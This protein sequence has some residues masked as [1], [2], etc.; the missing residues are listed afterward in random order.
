MPDPFIVNGKKRGRPG[1]WIVDYYLAPH[2]RT[3]RTFKTK[4]AAKAFRL[5]VLKEEMQ[6]RESEADL[7]AMTL[8]E[9]AKRR[10]LRQIK[11]TVKPRTYESYAETVRLHLQPT[12]GNIR[13]RHLTRGRIK[14][15]LVGK[16]SV[17]L[18]RN[19]VRIIQAVLSAMLNSAVDDEVILAN[20][21]SKLG[22]SLR[23]AAAPSLRQEQIKAMT[24][25]Q[26]GA[27]LKATA[28][29]APAYVPLFLTLARA[30][31]RLGEALGLHWDDLNFAQREIRVERTID[32]QGRAGTPKV[33]NG[34]TIQMSPQ[35]ATTLLRL[36]MGR[37]ERMKRHKWTTLPPWVFCTRSGR[38]LEPHNVR[39]VFRTCL[40]A[41][42]L[43]RHFTPHC[44][45]HTYASILLQEGEAP[46]YVQ[47]QL[48]HA[49]L[50]M[51]VDTY[52][53][54]LPKKPVQGGVTLLDDAEIPKFPLLGSKVGSRSP[55][56]T[57]RRAKK[58]G[59]PCGTRTHDP[60]IKSQVLCHL[61]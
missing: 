59:E 1:R 11:S 4:E 47:Q 41:A 21:A 42:E 37:A 3:W 35:L 33:G 20:P 12:L 36:H 16:L 52:G 48:G 5:Q 24:R 29:E 2:N 61:S 58:L 44:L 54:W 18:S 53:K 19:S 28:E 57:Q 6:A 8:A 14:A 34:R 45:R 10:W 17:G 26:L 38:T 9:Y 22:R 55:Q 13:I 27:F 25:E 50:K 40:K 30:G 56:E 43:S 15:L 7:F 32:S 31:L 39:R 46:Q 51:T 23:L 49:S 60:L